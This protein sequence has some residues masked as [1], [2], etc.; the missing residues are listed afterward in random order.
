MWAGVVALFQI[1]AG[2][3]NYIGER[4]DDRKA[5]KKRALEVMRDGLKKRD[6]SLITHSFNELRRL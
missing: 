3:V 4:D 2:I 6:A 5:Q 1:L